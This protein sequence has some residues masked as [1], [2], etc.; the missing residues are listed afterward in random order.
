MSTL[1]GLV[2]ALAVYFLVRGWRMMQETPPG[3]ARA[4]VLTELTSQRRKQGNQQSFLQPLVARLDRWALTLAKLFP[5]YQA[6][7]VP[8][9][10]EQRLLWAGKGRTWTGERVYGWQFLTALGGVLFGL[11]TG[12]VFARSIAVGA[13]AGSVFALAG[14]WMPVLWLDGEANKRQKRIEIDLPDMVEILATT[15]DAGLNFDQA[16]AHVQERMPEGPLR[17]EIG[18][19]LDEI[20]LGVP[21]REAFTRLAMRNRAAPMQ[22][23]AG[24][25]VQGHE[26]GVPVAETLRAQAELARDDRIQRA[27]ELAGQATPKITLVTTLLVVPAVL[28]L[29][30]AIVAQA[31]MRDMGPMLSSLFGGG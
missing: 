23:L 17:E 15:V 14:L 6:F 5:D 25:L 4:E 28:C 2:A 11:Y 31:V 27:R 22:L 19:F 24:A 7:L 18:I 26:L 9:D 16:L 3:R 20:Q 8:G 30:L 21:R 13:G 12:L 29:V 1:A 10:I